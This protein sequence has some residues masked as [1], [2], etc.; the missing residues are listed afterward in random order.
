MFSQIAGSNG[1]LAI[2]NGIELS[3]QNKA[4]VEVY[5]MSG[6]LEKTMN[7]TNGVYSVLLNDLPKG[8]HVAKISFSNGKTHFLTLTRRYP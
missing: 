5:S 3:V 4:R 7:F 6:R 8:M 1:V 2:K